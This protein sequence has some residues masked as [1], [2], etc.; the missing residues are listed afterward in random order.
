[1]GMRQEDTIQRFGSEVKSLFFAARL[2][3]VPLEQSTIQQD[4]QQF[5]FDQM[6]TACDFTR[7]TKKCDFHSTASQRMHDRVRIF[8]EDPIARLGNSVE[9]DCRFPFSCPPPLSEYEGEAVD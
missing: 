7:R 8:L 1:M 3:T 2:G 9:T 4:S 5:R 6:L